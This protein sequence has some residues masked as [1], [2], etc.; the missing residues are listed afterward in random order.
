MPTPLEKKI[1]SILSIAAILAVAVGFVPAVRETALRAGYAVL[2]KLG[3]RS[4]PDSSWPQLLQVI[5]ADIASGQSIALGA[6]SVSFTIETEDLIAGEPAEFLWDIREKQSG[7]NASLSP[8]M[9]RSPMH[10]YAIKTDLSGDLMHYHPTFKKERSAWRQR[11]VFPEGGEWLVVT[12]FPV[13]DTLYQLRTHLSLRERVSQ[14]PSS[15]HEDRRWHTASFAMTPTPAV[16][17]VPTKL[18]FSFTPTKFFPKNQTLDVEPRSNLI[19]VRQ[20]GKT[21]WNEHGDKSTLAL[22]R[23]VGI[24][25]SILDAPDGQAQYEVTF[26]EPGLWLVYIDV[27]GADFEFLVDVKSGP[28]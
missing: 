17:G 26:P 19:L 16:A 24:P 1:G 23:Q 2:E 21:L 20:Y 13:G 9:H 22:S 12:Q 8:V 15:T 25:V 5:E 7:R 27:V 18:T 11:M 14:P 6:L 28:R 3:V 4:V 10:T